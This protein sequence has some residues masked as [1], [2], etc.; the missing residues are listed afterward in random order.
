MKLLFIKM[1]YIFER[2]NFQFSFAFLIGIIFFHSFCR[3]KL[4]KIGKTIRQ[5]IKEQG[6]ANNLHPLSRKFFES[7]EPLLNFLDVSIM[8]IVEYQKTKLNLK[9]DDENPN[10]LEN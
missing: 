7:P 6:G 1:N 4:G 8:C 3:I 10:F 2:I 9:K 5:E